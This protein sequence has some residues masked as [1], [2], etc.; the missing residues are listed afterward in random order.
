MS[1]APLLL[2]GAGGHARACLDVIEAD[3]RFEVAGLFGAPSEVGNEVLGRRVLGTDEDLAGHVARIR[4][5]LVAVGQ[6]RTSEPRERLFA[7]LRGLGFEL[8]TVISPHAHVSPHATLGAGTIVMHGAIVNAGAR[9]G[10]NCILNSR[11]LV[12]HDA[13]VGDHSHVSTGAIVN[14]AARI[15]ARCFIGS[16]AI[17]REGVA[18][19]DDCV[20]GMHQAVLRDCAPGSRLTGGVR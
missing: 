8:P 10:A 14:G 3:G 16:G 12:E 13:Q 19:G 7:R 20:V 1:R 2:V 6:I 18:V 4:H 11:S 17:V 15:G 5:A 9:V